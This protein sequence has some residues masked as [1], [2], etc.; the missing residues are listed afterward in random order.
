MSSASRVGGAPTL[1]LIILLIVPF[2]PTPARSSAQSGVAV[3]VNPST[4][5]A[6]F[7]VQ[8]RASCGDDV[9]PA[10]A[11]SRAFGEITLTPHH[12]SDQ[13]I[14]W[15]TIPTST[16]PGDYRVD[17]RCANGSSAQAELIVLGMARPTRGPDTG[18]GGTADDA[19]SEDAGS[20]AE[21]GGQ[22]AASADTGGP[23]SG[24]ATVLFAGAGV[25]ALVGGGLL[26][27]RRR[28]SG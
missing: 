20:E 19:G 8:I 2:A 21:T 22:E 9:N 12:Q 7:Q 11:R 26:L 5:Q 1:L 4:I 15:A 17:L 6:G 10:T 14:G 16:D 13:L 28:R 24:N 18:G 23:P 3:E 25:I 27:T